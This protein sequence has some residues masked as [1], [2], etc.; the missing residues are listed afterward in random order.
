MPIDLEVRRQ[1]RERAIEA[2]LDAYG[3]LD[4]DVFKRAVSDARRLGIY[5]DDRIKWEL[6]EEREARVADIDSYVAAL[7]TDDETIIARAY[8][9]V[10]ALWPEFLETLDPD[11]VR[12]GLVAFKRWGRT[13][14]QQAIRQQ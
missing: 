1:Q 7:A 10:A 14:R 13:L 5:D 6:I 4:N 2:L 8:A 3:R 11:M 12:K 9:R